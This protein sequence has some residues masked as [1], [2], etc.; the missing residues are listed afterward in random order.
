MAI[1]SSKKYPLPSNSVGTAQLIDGTIATIDLADS[2]ITAGKIGSGAVTNAKLGS[3]A[4]SIDK[5]DSSVTKQFGFKNRIING[6]MQIWQRG[7]SLAVTGD[8][9]SAADRWKSGGQ[10]WTGAQSTDVPTGGAARYSLQITSASGSYGTFT[11]RIE[12]LNCTDLVGKDITI[13]FWA[14]NV[15]GLT[16]YYLSVSSPNSENNFSGAGTNLLS[17]TYTIVNGTWTKYTFTITNLPAVVA[18]GIQINSYND[19]SGASVNKFTLFQLE[20]G[21]TATE[22]EFRSH[23]TELALCQRYYNMIA[24]QADTGGVAPIANIVFSQTTDFRGII[25]FPVK[26]RVNPS[27]SSGSGSSYYRIY[28]G[29]NYYVTSIGLDFS[30]TS[31]IGILGGGGF[32]GATVGQAGILFAELSGSYLAASAEL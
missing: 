23:G 9:Y 22:F 2:S 29:S 21:S 15:S 18:N 4:V 5:V 25:M 32:S 16:N 10:A 1:Y 26:M 13:S 31:G 30:S 7:T 6:A 12:S 14:K 3:G 24:K 20:V 19:S 17:S 8:A 27:I 11:H 28:N